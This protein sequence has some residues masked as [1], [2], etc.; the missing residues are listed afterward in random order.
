ML[1]TYTF[2]SV[3]VSASTAV[4]RLSTAVDLVGL[5]SRKVLEDVGGVPLSVAEFG[6]G[7]S[8]PE[9][10]LTLL[11][12]LL[13]LDFVSVALKIKIQKKEIEFCALPCGKTYVS[14]DGSA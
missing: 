8:G 3:V 11:L 2:P 12:L 7:V 1:K 4:S 13:E 6:R 10:G 14:D 9:I 5:R